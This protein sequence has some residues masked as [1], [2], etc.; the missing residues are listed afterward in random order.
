MHKHHLALAAITAVTAAIL[1]LDGAIAHA[2]ATLAATAVYAAM[3][4]RRLFSRRLL[5]QERD[6]E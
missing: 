2:A 1:L 3:G 6:G 5:D 4:L